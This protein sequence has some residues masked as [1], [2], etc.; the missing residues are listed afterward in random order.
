VRKNKHGE[1][2]PGDLIIFEDTGEWCV[3]Q[4]KFDIYNTDQ[5]RN[6]EERGYH[7]ESWAWQVEWG[8]KEGSWSRMDAGSGFGMSHLNLSNCAQPAF[9]Q[10]NV[11]HVRSSSPYKKQKVYGE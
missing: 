7:S 8:H 1:W 5:T 11:V 4:E 2:N 9:R 6:L 10:R 3:L